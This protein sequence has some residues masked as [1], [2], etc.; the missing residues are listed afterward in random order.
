MLLLPEPQNMLNAKT[1]EK[2]TVP[3]IAEIYAKTGPVPLA[4]DL[5]LMQEAASAPGNV[6]KVECA[7]PTTD[8]KMDTKASMT[9]TNIITD[10]ANNT[11]A[12]TQ[13]SAT[14][15]SAES[16]GSGGYPPQSPPPN[17]SQNLHQKGAKESCEIPIHRRP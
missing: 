13:V 3:T 6:P 2:Q 10:T 16:G 15:V 7:E 4:C 14:K 11:I 9:D 1:E 5:T 12:D 17:P 8:D